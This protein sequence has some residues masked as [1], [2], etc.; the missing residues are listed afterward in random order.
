[1][2]DKVT[3]PKC[4]KGFKD[5]RGLPAHVKTCKGNVEGAKPRRAAKAAAKPAKARRRKSK[6]PAKAR[7][8]RV[9]VNL[10]HVLNGSA[11]VGRLLALK[12]ELEEKAAA[13]GRMADEL[14]SI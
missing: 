11:V 9:G 2:A 14:A 1:M 4:G 6:R 3:C 5:N 7:R 13:L 12:G 8:P 10:G